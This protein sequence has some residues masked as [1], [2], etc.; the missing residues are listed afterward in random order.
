LKTITCVLFLCIQITARQN[1]WFWKNPLPQGNDIT[2][3]FFIDSSS[4]WMCGNA[5]TILKTAQAETRLATTR[6]AANRRTTGL[7]DGRL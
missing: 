5:G 1:E 4:G 3:I 2:S 6:C 7:R